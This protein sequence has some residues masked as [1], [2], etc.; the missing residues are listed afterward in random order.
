MKLSKRLVMSPKE[1]T[2]NL[3][4][5]NS[6]NYASMHMRKPRSLYAV[7]VAD[8]KF[9]SGYFGQFMYMCVVV[10]SAQHRGISTTGAFI[11]PGMSQT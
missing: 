3:N 5:M 6:Y 1:I 10:H 2:C 9:W 8:Y 4:Y 7:H 11:L